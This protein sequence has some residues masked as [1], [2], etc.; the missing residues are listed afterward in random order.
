ME[1]PR[2]KARTAAL[3]ALT[4]AIPVS[5]LLGLNWAINV[6]AKRNWIKGEPSQWTRYDSTL[7]WR[8]MTDMHFRIKHRETDGAYIHYDF[9]NLGLR[10]TEDTPPVSKH[11]HRVL[12][13]GDSFTEGH[14]DTP[15]TIPNVAE[16][17]LNGHHIDAEV[18]NAGVGVYSLYQERLLFEELIDLS[19]EL[20]V[21]I[22]FAG[23]DYL[24]AMPWDG[25]SPQLRFGPDGAV[26]VVPVPPRPEKTLDDF[27]AEH[28]WFL[29][30][31]VR[32]LSR[33]WRSHTIDE[34]TLKLYERQLLRLDYGTVG[35]GMQ[36]TAYFKQYPERFEICSRLHAHVVQEIKQLAAEHDIELLF[37]ILPN[38]YQ[39]ERETLLEGFELAER[40][41]GLD[42]NDKFEDRVGDDF[43]RILDEAGIACLDPYDQ[44]LRDDRQLYWVSGQ[45]MNKEGC[46]VIGELLAED[47]ETML[48]HNAETAEQPA[49]TQVE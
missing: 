22:F 35:S 9:N 24:D 28:S 23:N 5:T 31:A 2:S 1:K 6:Y 19:P 37:I 45:H 26:Q 41:I 7:G 32:R 34:S 49:A 42:P 3:W 36:Q 4:I 33:M 14:V 44:L 20:A 29:Q 21:F 47:L 27:L 15:D 43:H 8:H 10:E 13:L 25:G 30:H 16:R 38:K 12:V 39:V 46:E 11:D 18:L 48:A 40:D 17:I